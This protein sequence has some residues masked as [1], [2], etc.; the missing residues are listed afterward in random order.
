MTFIN[1]L[2]H[3]SEKILTARGVSGASVWM[4]SKDV[5]TCP[6]RCDPGRTAIDFLENRILALRDEKRFHSAH[7]T[8]DTLGSSH[9]TRLN[10]LRESLGTKIVISLDCTPVNAQLTTDSGEP[11]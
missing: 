7:S 10:H 11:C 6:T 2:R 5:K 9:S 4:L 8:A 3:K 1:D